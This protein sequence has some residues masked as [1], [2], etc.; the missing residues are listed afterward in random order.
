M[1]R[2]FNNIICRFFAHHSQ[3]NV[4]SLLHVWDAKKRQMM[5]INFLIIFI[6]WC[7]TRFFWDF[8][9]EFSHSAQ[10][11]WKQPSEFQLPISVLIRPVHTCS[12]GGGISSKMNVP[13]KAT[14]ELILQ[15]ECWKQLL[16]KLEENHYIKVERPWPW[17]FDLEKLGSMPLAKS[18]ASQ[19][20]LTD[21]DCAP[22]S[23]KSVSTSRTSTWFAWRDSYSKGKPY[24]Y[25]LL[26]FIAFP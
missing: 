7:S 4:F 8:H 22:E 21:P 16:I 23:A 10:A 6:I 24:Y 20:L 9:Q 11:R 3:D 5:L 26:G 12:G 2:Q 13:R 1:I 19:E 15:L 17:L 25:L 18:P 14:V